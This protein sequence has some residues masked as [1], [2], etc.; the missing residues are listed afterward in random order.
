MYFI[1]CIYPKE[2]ATARY[3]QTRGRSDDKHPL[4]K[5]FQGVS[6][7]LEGFEGVKGIGTAKGVG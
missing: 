6:R 1:G 3:F 4:E 5:G 7:D 2:S